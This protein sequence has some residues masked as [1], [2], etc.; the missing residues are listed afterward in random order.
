M[1]GSVEIEPVEYA[2]RGDRAAWMSL[3]FEES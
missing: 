3:G 2:I 1:K